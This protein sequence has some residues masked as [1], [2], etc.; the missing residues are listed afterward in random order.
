[1]KPM[2]NKAARWLLHSLA[3][4]V[5]LLASAQAAETAA[6]PPSKGDH[7]VYRDEGG[8]EWCVTVMLLDTGVDSRPWAWVTFRDNPQRM[9]HAPLDTLGRA[10]PAGGG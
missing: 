10:C 5:P 1:M 7:V 9:E 6:K 4:T 3:A 2:A 8:H